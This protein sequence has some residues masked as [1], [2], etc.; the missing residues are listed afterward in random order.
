[1]IKLQY[2][3]QRYLTMVQQNK[4]NDE[5]AYISEIYGH[6]RDT[7]NIGKENKMGEVIDR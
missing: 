2:L 5:W 3:E 1:M 6:A 4:R 7:S